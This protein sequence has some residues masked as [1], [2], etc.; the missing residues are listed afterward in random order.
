MGH[1]EAVT[2]LDR[3]TP[4]YCESRPRAKLTIGPKPLQ[5]CPRGS[6]PY[7][8]T[9]SFRFRAV[10]GCQ[11]KNHTVAIRTSGT[12]N[13]ELAFAN[14]SSASSSAPPIAPQ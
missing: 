9:C 12:V 2:V 11:A 3:C 14:S 6:S 4:F 13:E 1:P 5:K 8:H 10:Y 7:R